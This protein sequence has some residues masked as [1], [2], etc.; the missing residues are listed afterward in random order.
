MQK[1][2]RLMPASFASNG[3]YRSPAWVVVAP[4]LLHAALFL[5]VAENSLQ[6]VR[7]YFHLLRD[8][9]SADAGVVLDQ[10]H[11][12][13]GA[14]AA[15]SFTS[16]TRSAGSFGGFGRFFVPAARRTA[17]AAAGCFAT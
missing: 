4:V 11:R 9:G 5:E 15:T 2:G 10:F 3:W 12:L 1:R 6:V 8:I 17:G 16:A 13:I 7:L 14:G